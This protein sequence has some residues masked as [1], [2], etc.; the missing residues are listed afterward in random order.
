MTD[1]LHLA[2]DLG[3]G[4]GRVFLA[5]LGSDEFLLEEVRR[6]HY[7]PRLIDR[8]LRWDALYIFSEIE[9]GLA[10]GSRRAKELGRRILSIGVDSWGVDYGLIDEYGNLV[11]DPVCYRDERAA[12]AM[13]MVFSIV[14]VMK[15]TASR[16]FRF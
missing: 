11:E 1:A 7:P 16:G 6:F 5:G 10:E 3:A 4:S 13:E 12:K 2:V 8:H 15:S 14:P 9:A